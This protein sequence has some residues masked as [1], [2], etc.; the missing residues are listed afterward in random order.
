MAAIDTS[1]SLQADSQRASGFGSLSS[2]KFTEIILTELSNQ[3]PL[4]PNDT[5]SLLDQLSSIRAIES[6][7][8]LTESLEKLISRDEFAT[9]SGLIGKVV[10]G[11]SR[12]GE[13]VVDTVFSVSQTLDDV[14]LNLTGG[15]AL[16]LADVREV[17]NIETLVGDQ[18][19]DPP[20]DTTD[21]DD[22]TDD[23]EATP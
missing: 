9:A 10:T 19:Q 21:D 11:L 13:P 18:N 16:R 22:Q 1:S 2:E 8:N 15:G 14:T 7:T 4:E 12:Q 17:S 23:E 3:D 6:D 20:A 5:Q